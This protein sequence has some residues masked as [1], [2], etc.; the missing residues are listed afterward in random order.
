MLK[1]LGL[2]VLWYGLGREGLTTKGGKVGQV[3]GGGGRGWGES[4][5][6]GGTRDPEDK[7]PGKGGEQRVWILRR[8]W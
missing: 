1:E 2:E 8:T 4:S 3:L 6:A 5:E 7:G